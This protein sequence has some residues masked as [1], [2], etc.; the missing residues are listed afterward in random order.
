M[1]KTLS[2]ILTAAAIIACGPK[3]DPQ[4]GKDSI[5]EV[6]S[7]MT[8]EEKARVLIG[9]GQTGISTESDLALDSIIRECR[10]K[11]PGAAGT[12]FPIE[13]LGIPAVVLTD[14]PA[15]VRIDAA[16]EGTDKTFY[17]THFPIATLLSATW[18][19]NL[20][21]KVGEAIGDE[22]LEYG[23]DVLLAPALNI[24]RHPLCGRNFEYFSED[25]V[26]SGKIAAAYIRG[27]QS[28]GV[29]TSIKHFAA[30]NQ[31]T[32]RLS[33]NSI[34]A[35][36]TLREIYLKGFEIAVKEGK[37]WTVMSAY[38]Y[39]NG[40]YASESKELLTTILRDEWGFDG[41][42]MTDWGAGS[43]P[44][45][46]VKA[47]NDMFQPGTDKQYLSIKEGIEK[48]TIDEKDLDR[49]VRRVLEMI[50]KTPGFK[51]YENSDNPDLEAN[52]KVTRESAT[53][54]MV[55]LKNDGQ[56]LPFPDQTKT[57]A[58]FGSISYDFY[59]G[60]TGSGN[61]V[62][63]YTVSLLDGLRNVGYETEPGIYKEYK[64]F[65]DKEIKRVSPAKEDAH[66]A[67]MP[68]EQIKE[69]MVSRAQI[70]KAAEASDAALI[71][72]GRPSGEFADRKSSEY[73]VSAEEKEL[74]RN[75][76]EIFHSKGKKA[77]VILNIGG[78]IETESWK[79]MPDAILCAWQAGQEGGNSVAD[80]LCGNATPSGKL[81]MTFPI[82]M[83]DHDSARNFPVDADVPLSFRQDASGRKDRKDI[84]YVIYEEGIYVGYRWFEKKD[85]R[86]SYPFGHG[87]SYTT[88]E[89][90]DPSIEAGKKETTINI[91]VRNT[92]DYPGKEVV[93]LYVS[94]PEGKLDKPVK[95]L[96]AF[97]KTKE[98][99]PG[100]SETV[101]LTVRHDDL[102]SFDEEEGA[103]ITENGTYT[104]HIGAS[105]AD[106][107]ASLT[108]EIDGRVRKVN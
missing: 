29:G 53:E 26:V 94:A 105:S 63:A 51:G 46:Q 47:G 33:C 56:T 52:A 81:P 57:L 23:A 12:T 74:I 17:C 90:A 4:L 42:V 6:I 85:M 66:S 3:G 83:Y 2:I 79:D 58:V 108:C 77:V 50:L 106:I 10:K 45:A 11:V 34:V 84:D 98:L 97:T 92:G 71:T 28:K 91:T 31:E 76:T 14:G 89:Y 48:G 27:V 36:R 78:V 38:N 95:E 99:Q 13:R 73:Y 67:L 103:W 5:E 65:V 9:T 101:A 43:D 35:P 55:L 32:N 82:D 62:R 16:R 102:A 19:Q 86:V 30:N 7:A 70:E 93:Q 21:E 15:G 18:N 88:F 54:G 104:F 39:V 8:L 72:I 44:A 107:K 96:K 75:V 80:V 87:L 100:E 49:N 68:R 64:E 69:M 37:P 25:P 59:A 60:G 1:K 24:H 40:V 61:V 41:M 20:V 22:V